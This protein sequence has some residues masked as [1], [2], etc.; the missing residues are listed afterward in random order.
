MAR[1]ASPY[2]PPPRAPSPYGAPVGVYPP[3]HVM[4]GRPV[5]GGRPISRSSSPV[6]PGAGAYGYA[7]PGTI[8]VAGYGTVVPAAPQYAIAPMPAGAMSPVMP[9]EA[10]QQMLSTPEGFARPPNLSQ[11][12]TKFETFK[13]QDMDGFYE[14]IPRMP[15]ALVPHDVYHEDWIRMMTVRRV[16]RSYLGQD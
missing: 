7:T 10:T 14:N 15:A 3:G 2:A 12:Y 13:I 16:G 1:A 9:T 4:E 8:P 5:A 11:P 6:Q